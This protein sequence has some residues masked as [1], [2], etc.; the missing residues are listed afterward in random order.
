MIVNGKIT[1]EM[2]IGSL[3]K[4]PPAS[5]LLNDTDVDRVST[6][7]LLGFH[8]CNDLKW[9]QHAD[10]I[11]SK[12]ASRLNF[13]RQLKRAGASSSDLLCFYCT[14]IRTM[15]NMRVESSTPA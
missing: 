15:L 5:L 3:T 2:L 9:T 12:L 8:I 13:L 6:L 10:A 4:N 14:V 1:K 7:K 11:S